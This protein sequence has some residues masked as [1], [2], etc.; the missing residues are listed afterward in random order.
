VAKSYLKFARQL[1]L[2]EPKSESF[3]LWLKKFQPGFWS[4]LDFDMRS[5]F[6]NTRPPLAAGKP[7]ERRSRLR[8]F[9]ENQAVGLWS[10]VFVVNTLP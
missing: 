6:E 9:I 1:M 8:Y 4:R 2:L 10:D 7:E 5:P 3:R